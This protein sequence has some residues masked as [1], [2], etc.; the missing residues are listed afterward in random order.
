MHAS[1]LVVCEPRHP[2]SQ[3]QGVIAAINLY[4]N[5]VAFVY[6]W[7]QA[8]APG[9]L[10]Q[11]ANNQTVYPPPPPREG[12]DNGETQNNDS[13]R[14]TGDNGGTNNADGGGGNNDD[15]GER[16]R[17]RPPPPPEGNN[18]RLRRMLLRS[19]DA[20]AALGRRLQQAGAS[21]PQWWPA[22]ELPEPLDA[23]E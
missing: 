17:R 12:N 11:V 15:E 4:T 23:C 5:P 18:R 6:R 8:S 19:G 20:P 10:P 3:V 21:D 14:G 7:Q 1:L 16:R 2:P 9:W 22:D 13:T